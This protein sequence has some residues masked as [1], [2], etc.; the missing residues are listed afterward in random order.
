VRESQGNKPLN[1]LKKK[2]KKQNGEVFLNRTARSYIMKKK[3]KRK[4]KGISSSQN[5]TCSQETMRKFQ[6]Q[7]RQTMGCP[8]W[9]KGMG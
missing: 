4:L 5:W 2:G 9:K 6:R 3:K 8:R 7:G 1:L